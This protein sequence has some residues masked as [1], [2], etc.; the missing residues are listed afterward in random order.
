MQVDRLVSG[1]V[2][3][4][5]L[6]LLCAE[7][8]KP[9]F[10]AVDELSQTNRGASCSANNDLDLAA[11]KKPDDEP[12]WFYG[13]HPVA[14]E[15]V[16]MNGIAPLAAAHHIKASS[17]SFTDAAETELVSGSKTVAETDVLIHADGL[18]ITGEVKTSDQLHNNGMERVK[19]AGKRALC[20]TSSGPTRSFSPQPGT[21]GS[22]RPSLR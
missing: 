17:K 18:V 2:L 6:A 10:V 22:N 21:S 9:A 4:R 11:W 14:R 13:L 20:A 12:L 5:G 3:R 8:R 15:L 1:R 16:Q 7:C 19:A